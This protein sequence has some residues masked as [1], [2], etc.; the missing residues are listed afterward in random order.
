MSIPDE[1]RKMH[2]KREF[3]D[4]LAMTL[5]GYV[6]EQEIFGDLTTGASNDLQK[7]TALA[8]E[9]VT[10][11]G[12]SSTLGPRTYGDREDGGYIMGRQAQEHR[13]YSEKD[14]RTDRHRNQRVP[15]GR[16]CDC[17]TDYQRTTPAHGP[18]CKGTARKRDDRER[19]VRG[20][21]WSHAKTSKSRNTKEH[22]K[23]NSSIALEFFVLYLSTTYSEELCTTTLPFSATCS[24]E[25]HAQRGDTKACGSLASWRALHKPA[26]SPTTCFAWRLN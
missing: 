4:D 23:E 15:P 19:S 17:T 25:P 9:L 2:S 18:C 20:T 14:R 8:R 16:T 6:A 11:F 22:S 3:I 13:D 24:V 12:M 21:H 10:Q 26:Q 7:A 5:G 1:D